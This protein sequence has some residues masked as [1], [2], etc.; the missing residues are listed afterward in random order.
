MKTKTNKTKV[1]AGML[2]ALALSGAFV[3]GSSTSKAFTI[4][5][6]SYVTKPPV[7]KPVEKPSESKEGETRKPDIVI[8]PGN[9]DT[10]DG[11]PTFYIPREKA[12]DLSFLTGG[13]D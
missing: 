9:G 13:C 6:D 12:P 4:R 10:S 1:V 7:Q 2:L 8:R 3:S 5:P 11:V